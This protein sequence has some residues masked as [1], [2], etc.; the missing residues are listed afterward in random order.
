M[1][2]KDYEKALIIKGKISKVV[3]IILSIISIIVVIITAFLCALNKIEF[4][5]AGIIIPLALMVYLFMGVL[6]LIGTKENR[7][8]VMVI[9]ITAISICGVLLFISIIYSKV[10]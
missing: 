5:K 6:S 1:A 3:N 7:K 9:Y 8:P 4:V 10:H 2:N